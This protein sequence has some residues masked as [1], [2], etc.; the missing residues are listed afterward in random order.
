M[1]DLPTNSRAQAAQLIHEWRQHQ[2]M[3]A[4][5]MAR[6]DL[7]QRAFINELVLGAVRHYRG[8]DWWIGQ[9]SDRPPA[10]LLTAVLYVGLY[11]LLLLDDV[12]EYAAV[13]ETVEAAKLL[14]GPRKGGF[15]NALLRR[16]LRERDALERGLAAQPLGVRTSHP[17]ELVQR[18]TAQFG[19]ATTEQ[20]CLWN[21]QRPRVLLRVRPPRQRDQVLADIQAA[22]FAA[23]PHAAADFIGWP[24]G[25]PPDRAPGFAQGALIV[26]DPATRHAVALLDPQPGE[27]LLDACAA[28]GGKTVAIAD[29]MQGR[30]RLIAADT[31]AERL[32]RIRE[33]VDRCRLKHV[34]TRQRDA[35]QPGETDCY[36]GILLDVPCSN[37]GVIQRRP[38]ART[39]LTPAHLQQLTRL[40]RQML[41]TAATQV[42]PGGRLVYSTCSLEPE[43]NQEQ[44]QR[45]LRDHPDY[46]LTAEHQSLPPRDQEDGAYAARLQRS[47]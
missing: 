9:L 4:R 12:E 46:T 14:T 7:P 23:T 45:W 38:D 20:L 25:A 11:Q 28:P 10:P 34:E 30:G 26:Q 44:V 32:K 35:T 19:A 16:A 40:Q 2:A 37:T 24:A 3:P 36:D 21:N 1:S 42:K 39:R 18:W 43:E 13:N 29:R 47:E 31:S 22:G 17:D 41:D 8:L 33:N 27:T 5:L 15:V 6:A